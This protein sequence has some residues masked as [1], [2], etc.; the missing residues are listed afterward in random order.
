MTSTTEKIQIEETGSGKSDWLIWR[1]FFEIF[2]SF[3][4]IFT[5]YVKKADKYSFEDAVNLT[6]KSIILL[7]WKSLEMYVDRI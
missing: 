4:K 7:R 2:F 6:R 1:I 3:C 5:E